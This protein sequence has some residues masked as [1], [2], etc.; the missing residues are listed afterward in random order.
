MPEK[1]S[2]IWWLFSRQ[3]VSITTKESVLNSALLMKN[4]NFRHLP[5]IANSGK[6]LGIISAQD[7]V[8]TINL[9]L[10]SSITA[11]EVKNALDIP[12][13]RV[14]T[15]QPIVVEPGDGL[16]EVIKKLCY[17]NV[18][19]LPVVNMLGVVEGIITLRDMVNLMGISSSPLNVPVSEIMNPN[20]ITITPNSS[21]ANSVELMSE[22]R[23]RRLPVTDESESVIGMLTNK[24]VL[25]HIAKI[26]G[27]GSG[28][29]GF[30]R[31]VSEFMATGV[32]NIG[33]QDDVRI[34]ANQMTTF[35]VG[36]L[37]IEDLPSGKIGLVTERDLI[38]TLSSKRGVDFLMGSV[39]YELETEDAMARLSS[40]SAQSR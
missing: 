27:G 22:R 25:R 20:V 38:R 23:V 3:T 40:F 8:D 24:D 5:V 11:E 37:V 4:R 35:G 21:L 19:A 1:T 12:V 30:E 6:I 36:G 28:P 29:S 18:G 9:T 7:I 10:Q 16:R 2:D 15:G 39:Q 34:A 32:I 26:V 31:R 13:E 33:H 17:H 14:M